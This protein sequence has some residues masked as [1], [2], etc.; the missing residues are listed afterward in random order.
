MAYIGLNAIQIAIRAN[1]DRVGPID[2][3]HIYSIYRPKP[4]ENADKSFSRALLILWVKVSKSDEFAKVWRMNEQ[5]RHLLATRAR[6][7]KTFL[8]TNG[9]SDFLASAISSPSHDLQRVRMLWR[10][11]A[12]VV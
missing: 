5:S 2:A 11:C 1:N 12:M 8:P 3:E 10:Q 6:S 7:V 9:L 4:R